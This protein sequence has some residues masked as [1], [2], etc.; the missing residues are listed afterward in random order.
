[1]WIEDFFE[2]ARYALRSLGRDP[3]LVFTV[4]LTLAACIGANTAVFSLA[5][6]ILI[7][8]LAYPNERQTEIMKLFRN[9]K[10]VM[11]ATDEIS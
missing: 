7:R 8:P 4:A 5:N 3:F 10:D 2:D 6:S 9:G 11:E 1:M